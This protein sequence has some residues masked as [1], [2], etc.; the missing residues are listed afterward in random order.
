MTGQNDGWILALLLFF[1]CLYSLHQSG[2]IQKAKNLKNLANIQPS[3]SITHQMFTWKKSCILC[4][5]PPKFTAGCLS[6]LIY[7]ILLVYLNGNNA[8]K[9]EDNIKSANSYPMNWTVKN[10]FVQ[11][12]K[13][14]MV[15]TEMSGLITM[16]TMFLFSGLKRCMFQLKTL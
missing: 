11:Y 2:S 7:M 8:A 4:N 5:F 10:W 16:R 12:F 6:R 9:G 13:E 14:G 15:T 1:A 3:W